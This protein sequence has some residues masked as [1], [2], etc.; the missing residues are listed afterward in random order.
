MRNV[1]IA[2]E[3]LLDYV[4]REGAF[5]SDEQAVEEALREYAHRKAVA[6]LFSLAGMIEWDEGF[7]DKIRQ[8]ERRRAQKLMDQNNCDT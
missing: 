1:T 2:D 3:K 4:R 6:G 5:S 7:P 8:D